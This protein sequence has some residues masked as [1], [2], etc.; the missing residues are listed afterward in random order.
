MC[1]CGDPIIWFGDAM[2]TTE[3]FTLTVPVNEANHYLQ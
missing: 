2:I 3:L 1:I